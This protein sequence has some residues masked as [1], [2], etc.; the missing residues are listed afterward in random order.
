[1]RETNQRGAVSRRK[2][3]PPPEGRAG[4]KKA[5]S[6]SGRGGL[7]FFGRFG[8]AEEKAGQQRRATSKKKTIPTHKSFSKGKLTS[9]KRSGETRQSA[10]GGKRHGKRE[11][12]CAFWVNRG[13]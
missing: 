5:T 11:G 4:A 10:K 7:R 2:N 12:P 8:K 13:G 3:S 6:L 9:E 1:M